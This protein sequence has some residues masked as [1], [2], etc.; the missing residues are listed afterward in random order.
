MGV[1][2]VTQEHRLSSLQVGVAREMSTRI[3]STD[4]VEHVNQ[5]E[6][7]DRNVTQR[8][9]SE[10]AQCRRHLVVTTARGMQLCTHVARQFG[11]ATFDGHVDVLVARRTLKRAACEL[12]ANGVQC[13]EQ[14][15]GFVRTQQSGGDQTANVRLAAVNVVGVQDMVKGV[16]LREV[17]EGLIHGR[18]EAPAPECHEPG[19][20][21]SFA[22]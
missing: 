6:R 22:P 1:Q 18:R 9:A 15:C 12:F 14:R 8:V 16:T 13:R 20:V 7:G 11:G 3:R 4:F 10:E 19:G 17:P 21:E 5:F 2:V